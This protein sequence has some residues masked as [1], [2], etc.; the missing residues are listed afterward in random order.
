MLDPAYLEALRSICQPVR[1]A[2]FPRSLEPMRALLAVLGNPQTRFPC[3]VVA[4][5]VG[6][7]TICWRIAGALWGNPHPPA[8]S[9]SWRGGAMQDTARRVPTDNKQ[10]SAAKVGLYT[11]PHLHSFR[12][13][14]VINGAM[15]SQA[16]F[17]AGAQAVTAA[18]ARLDDHYSTFERATALALWWFA[19]QAVN[20]AVL[21]VGMGGRWDAVNA[22]PNVLAVITPIEKEHIAMLGGSLQTIAWHK[23]G[24]MQPGGEVVTGEQPETAADV[25]QAEAETTGALLRVASDL[26]LAACVRLQARGYIQRYTLSPAAPALPG[27]LETVE[28][29]GRTV[30]IDGAHTVQSARRLRAAVRHLVGEA[31]PV[32]LVAGMLGDKAAADVLAVFDEPRFHIVLTQA[33]SHRA[34]A[35]DAL[36]QQAHLQ[37]ASVEIVPELAEVLAQV[38]TAPE[39]LFVVTGSLRMAAAAREAFGLLAAAEL[40][41][42]QATRAIFEG[43]DYLKRLV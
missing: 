17:I 6:K 40:D 29:G 13:R 10:S 15:I 24:I 21:E 9:P 32:R 1:A 26:A 34:L 8:P 43:E 2:D 37:Q 20:I 36:H 41:E 12:E 30:L 11:G 3:V 28:A 25:L 19:Q 31:A 18:A 4:G 16:E 23:A 35:P 22:V 38:H 42:A 14:F 39:R 5:S 27:R 33:P 7:G